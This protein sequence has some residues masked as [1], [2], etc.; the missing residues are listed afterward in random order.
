MQLVVFFCLILATSSVNFDVRSI[1]FVMHLL[2]GVP[3]SIFV[4]NSNCNYILFTKLSW[5][6]DSEGTFYLPK[7]V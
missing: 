7:K 5:P 1:V 4:L 6:G 3:F 2:N